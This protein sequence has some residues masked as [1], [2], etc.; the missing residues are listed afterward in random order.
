MKKLLPFA[1]LG[2]G[3]YLVLK[4]KNPTTT[5]LTTGG[6][7]QPFDPNMSGIRRSRMKRIPNSMLV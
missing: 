1:L 6:D 7:S 3:L 2:L 5:V 4:K